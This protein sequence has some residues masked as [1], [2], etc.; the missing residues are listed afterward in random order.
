MKR[1]ALKP[2]SAPRFARSGVAAVAAVAMALAACSSSS[3]PAAPAAAPVCGPEAHLQGGFCVIAE[4]VPDASVQTGGV[5]LSH[6]VQPI[7]TRYCG[8]VGCHV[9]GSLAGQLNLAPGFAYGALV[10]QVPS[11]I[12]VNPSDGMP[13]PTSAQAT[14]RTAISISRFTSTSSTSSW[15]RRPR[16]TSRPGPLG[17]KCPPAARTA[18]SIR[19]RICARLT[20]GSTEARSHESARSMGR[21]WGGALRGRRSSARL[22]R[23]QFVRRSGGPRRRRD[24][25]SHRCQ[26]V[27]R[28]RRRCPRRIL[29]ERARSQRRNRIR[30]RAPVDDGRRHPIRSRQRSLVRLRIGH[31]RSDF[32]TLERAL[33]RPRAPFRGGRDLERARRSQ[34][35][36]RRLVFDDDDSERRPRVR[37]LLRSAG[38]HPAGSRHSRHEPR[39][40][41]WIHR[42]ESARRDCRLRLRRRPGESEKSGRPHRRPLPGGQ[43]RGQ[44]LALVS[45]GGHRRSRGRGRNGQRRRGDRAS[46]GAHRRRRLRRRRWIDRRRRVDRSRRGRPRSGSRRDDSHPRRWS[47]RRHRR[48][49]PPRLRSR[50]RRS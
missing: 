14:S 31:A 21:L 42:R 23:D 3:A 25:R 48:A 38:P 39:P 47:G 4:A 24:H 16:P 2:T 34:S 49:R 44:P 13:S 35:A 43:P 10:N 20:T 46:G 1:R 22:H 32:P 45:P 9:P 28:R 26:R 36:A 6:D 5:T 7:F 50:R 41:K 37:R 33:L 18:R 30:V 27:R 40:R 11:E 12:Q 15:T 17:P 29:S 19:T 8:V